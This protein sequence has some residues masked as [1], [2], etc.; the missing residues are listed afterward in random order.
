MASER[1]TILEVEA[2]G[3]ELRNCVPHRIEQSGK[4]L[5]KYKALGN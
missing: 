3:M 4:H 1:Q 2:C 5:R